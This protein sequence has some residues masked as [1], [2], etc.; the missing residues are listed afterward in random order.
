[1][2]K[3]I[4]VSD[5]VFPEIPVSLSVFANGRS[6]PLKMII[7]NLSSLSFYLDVVIHHVKKVC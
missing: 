2:D 1:M 6:K 3:I 4:A 5:D 7:K